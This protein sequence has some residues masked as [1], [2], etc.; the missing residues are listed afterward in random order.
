[1]QK[2]LF[3]S[4]SDIT[5]GGSG[6]PAPGGKK[7]KEDPFQAPAQNDDEQ[8]ADAQDKRI[9]SV[10]A[11]Q[12]LRQY[13]PDATKEDLDKFTK[14]IKDILD[15]LKIDDDPNTNVIG[16]LRKI[17]YNLNYHAEARNH[18]AARQKLLSASDRLNV[19]DIETFEYRE[20]KERKDKAFKEFQNEIKR[21]QQEAKD[22]QREKAEKLI[23]FTVFQGRR[24][25]FRSQK[26]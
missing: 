2:Y 24:D 13:D 26:V 11:T 20:E 18:L 19:V 1:M 12:L 21:K 22:K 17:E 10:T 25:Q 7:K 3:L 5:G 16:T 14:L 8:A 4:S 15:K 6:K 23:D 9:E